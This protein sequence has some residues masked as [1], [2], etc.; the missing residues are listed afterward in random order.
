MAQVECE[1]S[2]LKSNRRGSNREVRT[3]NRVMAG[4]PLSAQ[5]TCFF[6]DLSIDRMPYQRGEQCQ[7][8][9]LLVRSHAGQNLQASHLTR[10]QAGQNTLGFEKFSRTR[11]ASEVIDQNRRVYE[12]GHDAVCRRRSPD[13]TRST[14]A[15][16]STSRPFQV[17]KA[18]RMACKSASLERSDR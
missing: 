14:K 16:L 4:Q 13:R 5:G 12:D 1:Q 6:G 7:S 10:V 2:G 9:C 8:T 3:I 15:A 11:V 18:A 17:P